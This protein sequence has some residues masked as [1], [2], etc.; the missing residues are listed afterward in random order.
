M[1]NVLAGVVSA[2]LQ[3]IDLYLQRLVFLFRRIYSSN[4]CIQTVDFLLLCQE[5]D[6]NKDGLLFRDSEFKRS[7]LH[8]AA[9]NNH[10]SLSKASISAGA[11]KMK[12]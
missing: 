9:K 6:H 11:G 8:W 7:L 4:D 3:V 5:L 12:Q 10:V 1:N 2:D